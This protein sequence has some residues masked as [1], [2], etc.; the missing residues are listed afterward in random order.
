MGR[1]FFGLGIPVNTS[2]QIASWRDAHL[3]SENKSVIVENF[4]ITLLF[5]GMVDESTIQKCIVDTDKIIGS[6]FSI[7]LNNVGFWAK[8]KVLFFASNKVDI[9][10]QTLVADLSKLALAHM[11][12]LEQRPYIPH[13]TLCRKATTLPEMSAQPKFELNFTDFCLYESKPTE[14]GVRYEVIHRWPL[15]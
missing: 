2:R 14:Q 11:I 3:P 1:Y 9:A 10:L 6:T 15:L 7:V 4:H 5:L 12:K 8:P 13:L